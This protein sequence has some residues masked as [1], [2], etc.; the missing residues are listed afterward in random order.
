[1]SI[2]IGMVRGGIVVVDGRTLLGLSDI[3]SLRRM[4]GLIRMAP[5]DERDLR[6]MLWTAY[7]HAQAGRGPV[8]VRFPRGVGTGGPLDEPLREIPIGASETL[9]EGTDIAIVAYGHP[10]NAALKAAEML[11]TD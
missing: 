3:A 8:G 10:V 9:R 11:A 7:R 5:R 4:P 1:M 2:V 6:H